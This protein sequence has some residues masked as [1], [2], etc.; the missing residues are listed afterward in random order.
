M[1][2]LENNVTVTRDENA[3]PH[4]VGHSKDDVSQVL[5]FVHAQD[6]LWQMEMLRMTAK[7]RLSEIVGKGAV[8][9]DTYFRALDLYGA[10]EAS[11]NTLIDAD[12]KTL[13]AYAQGVNQFISNSDKTAIPTK[14]L[15]FTLLR[16][17]PE[18]WRVADVI[19][20]MKM[21]A[22]MLASNVDEELL[23]LKFAATGMSSAEIGD[24][25]PVTGG[26]EPPALPDLRDLYE[27]RTIKIGANAPKDDR[28]AQISPFMGT[29]ASNSWAI[30]GSKTRSG[31]PI[32]ANDTHTYLSAPSTWYLAHLRVEQSGRAPRN[33]VGA[34]LPGIPLVLLGRSN[35][36]AWGVTN[37]LIDVQD[38]FIEKI[39]PTDSNL[40]LAP[41]GY[42]PFDRRIE[43]IKLRGGEDV[44]YQRRATRHGPVLPDDY[45]N[46]ERFLPK[47]TVA[48]LQ[49]TALSTDDQTISAGLRMWD[50]DSVD[51]FLTGMS[52]F[53]APVQTLIIADKGGRIALTAVGKI[54]VRKPGN[55][56]LGRSPSPGWNAT[57]D[58][59]GFIAPQDSPRS[60]AQSVEWIAAANNSLD[61]LAHSHFLSTDWDEGWRYNRIAD[62]V[63]K[64]G[65]QT[66]IQDS[67]RAQMDEF[68]PAYA[69]LAPVMVNAIAER[70]DVD[71]EVIR[72]LRKWDFA[73]SSSKIESVIFG[74]WLRRAMERIVE[75]DLGPSFPS[76]WQPRASAF[77]RWIDSGASRDWCDVSRT[78]EHETCQDV[79]ARSLEEALVDLKSRLGSD[80][81]SWDPERLLYTTS[82]HAPFS[83]IFILSS[84]FDV[85]VPS[86]GGAY[87]LNRTIADWANE[88]NPYVSK[89][90][91]SF[92][93]VFDLS[94]LNESRFIINTG[95]SGNFA[96]PY[97]RNFANAW[98]TGNAIK[99][100]DK[101]E[102]YGA[103]PLGV[104]KFSSV[105][106]H[107]N[108]GHQ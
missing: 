54:P 38:I 23:R 73:E 15:E 72:L 33:M 90:G 108:L 75:D 45:R 63:L 2:G 84:I 102:V 17:S 3:V 50:F 29:G 105:N 40:Y 18:P 8:G 43:T 11:A 106:K 6:R 58:W 67:L 66:G 100:S 36:V 34:T 9:I 80:I 65:R 95:Q 39:H 91:T 104:W 48:A 19:A 97:Y 47:D 22:V 16:H 83:R 28:L 5:G 27:F 62:L 44:L 78:P 81:T 76:Y 88:K 82:S 30:S 26:A 31:K 101:F 85:S 94:D 32:L 14:S 59:D 77:K 55:T 87:T 35:E 103:E 89:F 46:I 49:W 41:G 52:D 4:I 79:L 99:I 107:T 64:S 60:E 98:A 24:L 53:V 1:E 20:L 51:D 56:I 61:S 70:A 37:S 13:E 92:R 71:D 10:A 86:R 25:L 96:S 57:Y 12:R 93:S 74:A 42:M 21:L 68:S 7:G 69:Q